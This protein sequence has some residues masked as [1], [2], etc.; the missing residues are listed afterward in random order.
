MV[1]QLV[2]GL[3]LLPV[4]DPF[5][6]ELGTVELVPE[7]VQPLLGCVFADVGEGEVGSVFGECVDVGQEGQSSVAFEELG[8]GFDVG[9]E[10]GV[11][12]VRVGGGEDAY[13]VD[14]DGGEC[15]VLEDV[16]D[17]GSEGVS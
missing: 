6:C 4:V 9:D 5:G 13:M 14:G 10:G 1:P 17:V 8:C 15:P 12:L 3:E 2:G 11:W 7:R 16:V